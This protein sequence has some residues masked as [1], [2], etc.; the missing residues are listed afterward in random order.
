MVKVYPSL[1]TQTSGMLRNLRNIVKD[2]SLFGFALAIYSRE[3]E[4]LYEGD[5]VSIFGKVV[6]NVKNDEFAFDR[7]FSMF[8]G[9]KE[10][11][12]SFLNAD[13]W[14]NVLSTGWKGC[15]MAIGTFATVFTCKMLSIRL[16]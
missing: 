15:L 9:G 4:M 12:L 13:W 6:Y 3:C 11:A 10:S 16:K 8:Q 2:T 5:E 14:W 1:K 7:C